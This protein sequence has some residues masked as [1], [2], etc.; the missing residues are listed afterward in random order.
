MSASNRAD[1]RRQVRRRRK[2]ASLILLILVVV[3]AVLAVLGG[4]A[5][6]NRLAGPGDYAG[7]GSGSVVVAVEPGDSASAIGQ[8]LE[9][10][11]VVKSAKAF[12]NAAKAD[13]RSLTIQPGGYRLKLQ[14]SAKEALDAMLMPSSRVA[15]VTIPEGTRV[16]K[17]LALIAQGT[18]ISLMSLQAAVK[19]G[20]AIGL[21]VY[22]KGS[23]EGYLFPARYDFLPGM[24]AT[25]AL[26]QMVTRFSTTADSVDL[27]SGAAAL[28]LTPNEVMTVASIVQVEV[29]PGDYAK[30]ARVIYNRLAAGMKLQL[31][32]TVLYAL[33]KSGTLSVSTADTRVDSPYNTYLHTGLP[34]GPI[35]SPGEAAIKAALSPASGDWLYFITTDPAT[36]TT[37]FTNSYSEFL[38]LKA[39]S[40]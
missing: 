35:N 38:K 33:G 22:A 20:A 12:V 18:A 23:A 5:V 7:P 19:D 26:S 13:A 1:A 11:G 10:A 4:I 2:R 28:K 3:L 31:D 14:M 34:P 16:P 6:H 27:V 29:A 37:V 25:T 17:T 39:Q 32:S 40:T 36:Q 24:T 8:T 30:A 15:Q 21:P 9:T